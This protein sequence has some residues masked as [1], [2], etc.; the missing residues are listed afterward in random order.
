MEMLLVL[1]IIS[2]L[3]LLVIPNVIQTKDTIDN[4]TC[5]AYVALVN[6]QIQQYALDRKAYPSSIEELVTEGYIESDT[7][8]DGRVIILNPDTMKEAII[9]EDDE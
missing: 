7:C 3:T 5:S 4:K 2:G 8:P 9:Q 1:L 6:S